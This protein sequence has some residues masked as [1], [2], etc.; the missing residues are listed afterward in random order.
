MNYPYLRV[1]IPQFGVSARIE[2]PFQ[3]IVQVAD[4]LIRRVDG[5]PDDDAAGDRLYVL[6]PRFGEHGLAVRLAL[7]PEESPASRVNP[8]MVHARRPPET[9]RD[10]SRAFTPPRHLRLPPARPLSLRR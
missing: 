8:V 2:Q 3:Q 4:P 5:D 6:G 10:A 7:C 9:Q 1:V